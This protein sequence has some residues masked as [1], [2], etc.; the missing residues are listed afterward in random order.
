[1]C[2]HLQ[3]IVQRVVRVGELGVLLEIYLHKQGVNRTLGVELAELW[4][5]EPDRKRCGVGERRGKRGWV[6]GQ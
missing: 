1:M 2:E 5:R 3:E 4:V 6:G